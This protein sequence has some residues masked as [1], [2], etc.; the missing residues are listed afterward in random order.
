MKESQ[1]NTSMITSRVEYSEYPITG[2]GQPKEHRPV[3]GSGRSGEGQ[4]TGG[5]KRER[6]CPAKQ[7]T[8]A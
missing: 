4:S 7:G 1:P 6:F 3:S 5:A 2:R 8:F